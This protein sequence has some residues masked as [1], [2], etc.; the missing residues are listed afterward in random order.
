MNA[1][2]T[3]KPRPGRRTFLTGLLTGA[4]VAAAL[5]HA[6][7]STASTAR[8]PERPP[9]GAKG[10]ILYRRTADVER[11]YRSLYRS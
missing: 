8:E 4:G 1:G 11:Y 7:R 5:G 3:P 9:D 2:E 10:A 6:A